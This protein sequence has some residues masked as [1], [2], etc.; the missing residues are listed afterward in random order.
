MI[1]GPQG[2]LIRA[3]GVADRSS[4]MWLLLYSCHEASLVLLACSIDKNNWKGNNVVGKKM[5]SYMLRV[6]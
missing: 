3:T 1:H 5:K 4:F 2:P 6:K